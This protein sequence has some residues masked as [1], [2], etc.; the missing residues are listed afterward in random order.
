MQSA[1]VADPALNCHWLS[2]ERLVAVAQSKKPN[3]YWLLSG[4]WAGSR[5]GWQRVALRLVGAAP[6]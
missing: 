3:L 1:A 4:W 6:R 2:Q 5:E